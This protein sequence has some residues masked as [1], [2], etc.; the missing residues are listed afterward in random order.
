MVFITVRTAAK[1]ATSAWWTHVASENSRTELV[2]DNDPRLI[3]AVGSILEHLAERARMPAEAKKGLVEAAETSC[4]EAFPLI[5]NHNSTLKV[6]ILDYPDRIEVMLEH[7]GGPE[8]SAPREE[9]KSPHLSLVDRVHREA[10]EGISR[11]TLV[12]YLPKEP[13]KA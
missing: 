3:R 13:A 7:A 10:C 2:L 1:P 12:K 5:G 11:T 6:I 9:G 4:R 8:G